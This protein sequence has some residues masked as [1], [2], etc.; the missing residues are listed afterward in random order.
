MFYRLLKKDNRTIE[1]IKEHYLLE[2]ELADKLRSSTVE[3]R[4][5]LYAAV[6]D[7]FYNKLS[8]LP[9]LSIANES[10]S[11]KIQYWMTDI[12][13]YLREGSTYLEIGAGDCKLAL[14]V[15]KIARKVYVIE[16]SSEIVRNI[17]APTNF[18]LIL[19][20]GRTI[21]LPDGETVDVA[22]SHQVMEHL[23]PDDAYEQLSNVYHLLSPGGVYICNTPNRINGPHDISKYFD[24][25]AKGFHLKEYTVSELYNL[26]RKIGFSKVKVYIKIRSLRLFYPILFIRIL[27]TI[28]ERTPLKL[29]KI[30]TRTPVIK[31]LLIINIIGI[32]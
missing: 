12:K 5:H 25:E 6:Y 30:I 16:V 31:K 21:D 11:K 18:R 9:Q 3:E 1:Q 29:R 28:F 8:H 20:D 23:H 10:M 24:D 2:K 27:E 19:T 7:E 13:P 26:F 17:E 15:A 32:K 22:Y 14:E 4:R